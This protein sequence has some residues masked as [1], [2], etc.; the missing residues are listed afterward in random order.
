M[1]IERR[2]IQSSKTAA[3][4]T[5]R[6]ISCWI[7]GA[8]ERFQRIVVTLRLHYSVFIQL[9]HLADGAIDGRNQNSVIGV[10]GPGARAQGPG[11][12][13]VE[14][15]VRQRVRLQ[16]IGHVRVE[17]AHEIADQRVLD[18]GRAR[19]RQAIN[20]ARQEVLRDEVLAGDKQSVCDCRSQRPRWVRFC[21]RLRCRGLR[22]GHYRC[23]VK[24]GDATA[25]SCAKRRV[26]NGG[27]KMPTIWAFE[28]TRKT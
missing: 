20:H 3:C 23:E 2:E 7:V 18:G 12:K 15:S 28:L 13:L 4:K 27:V 8:E 5:R 16:G 25:R 24:W 17:P 19:A 22:G 9:S 26:S 14:G 21:R 6:E 1:I 11:K 10:C